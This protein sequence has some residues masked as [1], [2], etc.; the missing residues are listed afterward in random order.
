MVAPISDTENN[1]IFRCS[2]DLKDAQNLKKAVLDTLAQTEDRMKVKNVIADVY[3]VGCR[4]AGRT[5]GG[6]FRYL[7]AWKQ[8]PPP[9]TYEEEL[10]QGSIK[11]FQKE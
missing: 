3:C 6:G 11:V 7:H 10:R 1:F 9:C 4:N 5:I 2:Q 8:P